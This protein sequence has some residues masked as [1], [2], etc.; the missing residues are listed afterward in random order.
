MSDTVGALEQ[1][2]DVLSRAHFPLPLASAPHATTTAREL[3][4][5][6]RDYLIPRYASLEAPLVAVVG[7]STGAGKSLLVNTLVQSPVARSSAI[8]PTT[9]RPLLVHSPADAPWFA[10]SRV[11]P[12]MARVRAADHSD[13]STFPG[14]DDGGGVTAPGFSVSGVVDA[15][16]PDLPG[17]EVL[18]IALAASPALPEGL[19][20]LD[21]P[22][23]DSV[24]EGNRRLAGY[25]LSAAD[26]WIFVTTAAR[27]ADAIPWQ[28]LSEAGERNIVLAVVL[29]RVPEGV[30]EE[31]LPDLRQ[32][33]TDS[34][35]GGAPVFVI[36]ERKDARGMI[37][38]S[39]TADLRRWIVSLAS[40]ASSRAA[41]ARQTLAGA[42]RKLLSRESELVEAMA[43]QV[44]VRDRLSDEVAAAFDE[45]EHATSEA[46]ADGTLL[47]S[48]VV[49]RW[50]D[51][52]GTGEWSRRLE[53]GVATVRDRIGGWFRA[54][55]AAPT[56][57]VD[58]ALEDSLASVLVAAAEDGVSHVQSQW[59]LSSDSEPALG[60]VR[61]RTTQEREQ[62]AATLVRQ[63]QREVLELVSS[64][65]KNKKVTARVLAVGVN[66]VGV[67]L[68]V[69][70]FA[71]TAG[72]TGAEV[73]VAGGTAVAAQRVLEAVFG[74]DAVRRM[75]T[76][77]RS[78]L[79][80]RAREFFDVDASAF[81][82]ALATLH[83]DECSALE[84]SRAFE[85]VS[86]TVSVGREEPR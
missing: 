61:L 79:V 83:V 6:L 56:A 42:T 44:A 70:I 51:V 36:P 63:W 58:R 52:V 40:D 60:R 67:A 71:S 14:V 7:G 12:E 27:Y 81:T 77:A 38:E 33:L 15:D 10:D 68:M 16:A 31:I 85:T 23:I 2:E 82:E 59:S 8:R 20:L 72:L 45:A 9:R 5:Q 41:V 80:Q 19:A 18:E 48:E 86:Q 25:L 34:G 64:T 26:L 11:L 54:R 62:S 4:R 28:L 22:D 21:S 1:L 30:S 78:D 84:I 46:L 39:A 13:G 75:T 55:T 65:G 43:Q 69:V 73:A 49:A 47:R 29:N 32:R 50:Q 74:D 17:P 66:V 3:V 35:L 24:V 76:S 37:P 57:E 53:R